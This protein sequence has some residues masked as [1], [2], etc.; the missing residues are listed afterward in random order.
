MSLSEVPDWI[1]TTIA[2][3]GAIYT[4]YKVAFKPFREYVKYRNARNKALEVL[5]HDLPFIKM[6][7][8]RSLEKIDVFWYRADS[9]GLTIEVSPQLCSLLGYSE[10]ELKKEGWL[11][12]VI[13]QDREGMKKEMVECVVSLRDFRMPATFIHRDGSRHKYFVTAQ[14]DSY[15][16]WLGE[17]KPIKTLDK[18]RQIA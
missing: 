1:K 4:S 9:Q 15:S 2:T 8:M 11:S 3:V 17:L 10:D 7:A 6:A 14:H 16:G 13:P 12:Y 18:V 5:L